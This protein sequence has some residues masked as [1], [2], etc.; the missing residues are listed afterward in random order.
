MNM[1][2]A[3]FGDLGG[4]VTLAVVAGIIIFFGVVAMIV[5]FIFPKLLVRDGPLNQTISIGT[6]RPAHASP[7][8]RDSPRV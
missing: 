3:L 5:E 2:L 8:L 7:N 1:L 4:L 6:Y